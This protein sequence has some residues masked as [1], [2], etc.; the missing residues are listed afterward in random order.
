MG[1]EEVFHNVKLS[2]PSILPLLFCF[3]Y[4]R[5]SNCVVLFIAVRAETCTREDDCNIKV[6]WFSFGM[7]LQIIIVVAF[8][9][10]KPRQ[11]YV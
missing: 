6:N 4:E 3:F 11:I 9:I 7:A 5:A 10:F 8:P 1:V 2:Y